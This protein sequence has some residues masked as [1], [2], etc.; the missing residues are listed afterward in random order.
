MILK[1]LDWAFLRAQAC[2]HAE[3]ELQN[4]LRLDLAL[5]QITPAELCSEYGCSADALAKLQAQGEQLKSEPGLYGSETTA[6]AIN[7]SSRK[8]FFY[9]MGLSKDFPYLSA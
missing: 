5:R 4:K 8:I 1:S 6:A 9:H 3:G 2:V 7:C